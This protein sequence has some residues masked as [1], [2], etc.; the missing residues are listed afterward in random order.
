MTEALELS[1]G[2][3]ERKEKLTPT[4]IAEVALTIVDQKGLDGLTM[5]ALA[6]AM[7]VQCP[8]LYRLISDKQQLLS[9][10]A[11]VMVGRVSLDDLGHGEPYQDLAESVRRIRLVLLEQRDGARIIGGSFCAKHNTLR[12]AEA[13]LG[14][15]AR[16]G[17][18]GS[19]AMQTMKIIFSFVLGETLEQQGLPHDAKKAERELLNSAREA[20]DDPYFTF[21]TFELLEDHLFQFEQC[22]ESGLA[23]L[24]AWIREE[25]T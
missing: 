22:F 7:G 19:R 17:L 12:A 2:R 16:V 10:M 25:T 5:R 15:M 3:R 24:L 13:M 9:E 21:L 18:T 23:L 14:L 8:V 4:Q 1:P 11:E 6:D 20:L